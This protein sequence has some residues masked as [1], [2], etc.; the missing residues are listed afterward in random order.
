MYECKLADQWIKP[1]HAKKKYCFEAD[2]LKKI[3]LRVRINENFDHQRV[4]GGEAGTWGRVRLC[5][6]ENTQPP[7]AGNDITG[8]SSVTRKMKKSGTPGKSSYKRPKCSGE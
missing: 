7:H 6:Y 1:V 3:T 2:F 4:V 5:G 8:D